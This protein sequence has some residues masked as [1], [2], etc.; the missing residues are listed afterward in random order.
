MTIQIW[1]ILLIVWC[2]GNAH[3]QAS[4]GLQYLQT[5]HNIEIDCKTSTPICKESS[6]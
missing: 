1:I 2:D 5:K 6:K 3:G 4:E